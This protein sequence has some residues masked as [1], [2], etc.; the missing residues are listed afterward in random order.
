MCPAQVLSIDPLSSSVSTEVCLRVE[1]YG[2]EKTDNTPPAVNTGPLY[3]YNLAQ[4]TAELYGNRY[5]DPGYTGITSSG[6]LS[7][8]T[9]LLSDGTVGE[10]LVGQSVSVL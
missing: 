8:G 4:P 5:T 9:G 2:C 1:V 7:G 3:Q 6:Y 10:Q